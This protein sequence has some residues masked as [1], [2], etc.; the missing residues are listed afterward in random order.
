[1]QYRGEGGSTD[2]IQVSVALRDQSWLS[3]TDEYSV[4]AKTDRQYR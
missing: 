3:V 4:V 1:M 2:N